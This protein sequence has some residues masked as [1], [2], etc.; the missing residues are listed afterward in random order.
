MEKELY[1]YLRQN[2]FNMKG[3][4]RAGLSPFFHFTVNSSVK[5]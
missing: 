1:E 4:Q 2:I 5:L 3:F